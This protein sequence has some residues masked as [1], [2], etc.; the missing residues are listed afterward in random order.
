MA[1]PWATAV[2][3]AAT[4]AVGGCTPS[5]GGADA[6]AWRP[7]TPADS[8]LA[9]SIAFHD[10]GGVWGR[11]PVRIDWSG[12]GSDGEPRVAI[13]LDLAPDPSTLSLSGEYLGSTI[14]Y[15]TDPGGWSAT[16]DGVTDLSPETRERMRLG[17]EDGYFWRSY[18]GFL[19]GLPMKLRD[20][21]TRI[22][23]EPRDEVFAGRAVKTIRVTYDPS[24]GGD[25]WYFYFDP[26][27]A[28]LVGARFY[29]DETAGDGEYLIFED[30]T[31]AGGLTIPR[32]RRWFT[33][34]EDRF[35]G[36]DDVR[37][38]ATGG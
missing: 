17:R 6:G 8:L 20:P 28:E 12:T 9:G 34:A 25:I 19:A 33:N 2:L 24:V 29:H 21:G 5:S 23:P 30:R 3:A 32:I 7:A 31:A 10:P 27:T 37:I 38:L 13:V 18:F 4:A 14:E 35:L 15:R 11:E 26:A 22:D 1:P 36:A 16:V